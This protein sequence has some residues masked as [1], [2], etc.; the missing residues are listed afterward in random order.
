[1][2]ETITEL[3]VA[4][5]PVELNLLACGDPQQPCLV[6]VHGLRD[7]AW[8]LAPVAQALAA[9][10]AT[11]P[12]YYVVIMELRGH[13]ASSHS[14]GYAMANFLMDL[15][16]VIDAVC[17]GAEHPQCALFG[18][19]LGGHLVSRYAALFAKRVCALLVVEGLGPPRAQTPANASD[20]QAESAKLAAYTQ[21]LLERMSPSTR[22]ST[23]IASINAVVER[24]LSN[25]PRL[26]SSL[27]EVIAPHLVYPV[28]AG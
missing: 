3:R 1:M 25:N 6:M 5:P 28:E 19:S 17:E 18:H 24:L 22:T 11:H 9:G 16:L 14:D 7:T 15:H 27:A 4:N 20:R 21:M 26:P 13:G 8:A 23:P 12:G 10:T 2:A